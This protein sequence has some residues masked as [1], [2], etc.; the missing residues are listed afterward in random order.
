MSFED[1]LKHHIIS[2]TKTREVVPAPSA[3]DKSRE[4][5]ANFNA[6]VKSH[7]E[8]GLYKKD[9][10]LLAAYNDPEFKKCL[11]PT[12]HAGLKALAD[13]FSALEED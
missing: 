9:A 10:R 12:E 7:T 5:A 13:Q 1:A 6:V 4:L 11:M 3:L 2:K 8:S